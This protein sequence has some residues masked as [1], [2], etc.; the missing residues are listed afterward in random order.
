MLGK[1][2]YSI[3]N[4]MGLFVPA[5]SNCPRVLCNKKLWLYLECEGEVK[6]K[7]SMMIG[8]GVQVLNIYHHP[9][10][11]YLPPPFSCSSLAQSCFLPG[12]S[13]PSAPKQRYSPL[14]EH[15]WQRIS[16]SVFPWQHCGPGWW[17]PLCVSSPPHR[18]PALSCWHPYWVSRQG[19]SAKPSWGLWTV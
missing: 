2:E 1:K 11:T 10:N 18:Q 14:A 9:Q 12:L 7:G 8:A 16:S 13:L 5:P 19:F 4:P 15:C 3:K 6:R 17:V